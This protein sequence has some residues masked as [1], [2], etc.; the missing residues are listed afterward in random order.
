MAGLNVRI[1]PQTLIIGV[2][3]LVVSFA[4]FTWLLPMVIG[5]LTLTLA[6]AIIGVLA[7]YLFL[8]SRS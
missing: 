3:I 6:A 8:V 7:W 2:V 4:L 5:G 1:T